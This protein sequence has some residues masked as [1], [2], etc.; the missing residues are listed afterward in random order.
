MADSKRQKIVSDIVTAMKLINGAGSY[1]TNLG[2]RVEDSRTDWDQREMPAISVFDGDAVIGNPD[3]FDTKTQ[4]IL[5]MRVLVRGFVEQGTTAAD[6]RKL[7]K[8]IMTAIRA[9]IAA[10]TSPIMQVR[11]VRDSIVREK[12]SFEVEACEVE[13]EAQF[14]THKFTAES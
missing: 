3:D 6:A 5:T 1:E 11:Q 2:S 4:V 9:W 7:I 12:D 13:I 10:G 14:V 8:D